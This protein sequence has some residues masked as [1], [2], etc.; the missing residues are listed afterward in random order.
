[1]TDQSS[2]ALFEKELFEKGIRNRREV[3]GDTFVDATLKNE[4]TK[5]SQ[6]GQ[7]LV[8]EW[9]WVGLPVGREIGRLLTSMPYLPSGYR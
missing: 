9:C 5:F 6:P 3:V 4:P 7:E 2:S 1:M 8:T